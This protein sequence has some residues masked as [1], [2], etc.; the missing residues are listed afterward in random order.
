MFL[1]ISW[2]VFEGMNLNSNVLRSWFLFAL[3]LSTACSI[4]E[5]TID[6]R[7]VPRVI[8]VDANDRAWDV[9][10]PVALFH[11]DPAGFTGGTGVKIPLF[12]PPMLGS[13]E[14]RYPLPDETFE[15]AGARLGAEWRAYA[16]STVVQGVV[17]N[18][19]FG[20][21]ERVAVILDP[22]NDKVS[23]FERSLGL[24]PVTLASTGWIYGGRTGFYD[25]E[26]E[27][28]WYQFD[29]S[30]VLTCISGDLLRKTLESRAVA[31]T[32]WNNWFAQ[33]M[34]TSVFVGRR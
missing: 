1:Q 4:E 14:P 27:S 22:V 34:D 26:T 32:T 28:L 13:T 18:D 30:T 24:D 12:N 21:F 33:H 16:L 31:R 17:I 9:T 6:E 20:Q 23:S 15:I 7:A 8:I 3:L 10:Q 29:G 2:F 25:F 19:S 11:F 5:L